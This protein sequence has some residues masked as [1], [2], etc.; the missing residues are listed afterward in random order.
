MSRNKFTREKQQTNNGEEE[1][2][3]GAAAECECVH[4]GAASWPNKHPLQAPHSSL[5]AQQISIALH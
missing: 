5:H 2:I 1:W 4:K 3:S